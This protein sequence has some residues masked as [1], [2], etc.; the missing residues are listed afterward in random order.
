MPEEII[1]RKKSQR[2]F[3]KIG[4]GKASYLKYTI[5][6]NRMS[7]DST[8]TPKEFRGRGYA[9][10][11]MKAAIEFAK[12]NNLKIVPNCTYAQYYFE[13]HPELKELLAE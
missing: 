8:Y 10:K 12:E 7:I 4:R 6:G 11:L 1:H 2:F 3:L 9:G 13:K 5:G